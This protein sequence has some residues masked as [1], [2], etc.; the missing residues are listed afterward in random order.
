LIA[1]SALFLLIPPPNV[2]RPMQA[3]RLGKNK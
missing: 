3:A 2:H 1:F